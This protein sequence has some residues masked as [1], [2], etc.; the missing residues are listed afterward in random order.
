[1]LWRRCYLLLFLLVIAL[2]PSLEGASS[3]SSP[4]LYI[5]DR[6]GSKEVYLGADPLTI[7]L[8]NKEEALKAHPLYENLMKKEKELS[9]YYRQ[10]EREER[11]F[12]L[13][14]AEI[15]RRR[16]DLERIREAH[17]E[18]IQGEYREKIE[19]E[20]QAFERRMEDLYREA[21]E[22]LYREL[23]IDR[24]RLEREAKER[25][26]SRFQEEEKDCQL[27]VEKLL[28]EYKPLILNLRI[29]LLVLNLSPEKRQALEEE[30]ERLESD[31]EIRIQLRE[32]DLKKRMEEFRFFI[33][34]QV[35]A[36]LQEF[37]RRGQKKIEESLR[38][39]ARRERDYLEELTKKMSQELTLLLL[40]E[41]SL[42]MEE[43]EKSLQEMES[44][45]LGELRGRI[46]YLQSE[47]ERLERSLDSLNE[48]MDEDLLEAVFLLAKEKGFAFVIEKDD[49]SLEGLDITSMVMN[50][51]Q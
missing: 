13:L 9:H 7:G 20:E 46:L 27:Y 29:K 44:L 45:L 32:E 1:M 30:M 6:G 28:E 16:G 22:D 34:R 51:L 38:V 50:L 15:E 47:I 43:E 26:S 48:Q 8:L 35:I 3:L 12:S 19:K 10:L 5:E 23:E 33:D 14:V 49:D 4:I 21:T 18:G 2:S 25:L 11:S 39:I 24:A 31:L 41:K 42:F 37:K 17:L 40:Q 36:Q